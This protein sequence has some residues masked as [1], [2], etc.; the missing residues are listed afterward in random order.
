MEDIGIT[1]TRQE[2]IREVVY[3]RIRDLILEGT[4]DA[5][6]RLVEARIASRIGASRTPVREALHML[7]REGL[8]ESIPRVGYRVREVSWEEVEEICEIRAVN[9]ILA[10]RWAMSRITQEEIH[11]LEENIQ[12]AYKKAQAGDVRSFVEYDA[13]FHEGIVRASGS[14][15]LMELCEQLRRHMLRYRIKSIFLPETV[16]GALKGHREIL[17]SIKERDPRGIESAIKAH[18]EYVKKSIKRHV[19]DAHG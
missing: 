19:F 2:S 7:E 17:K 6:E 9:E 5:G 12:R 10:A 1:L 15:R 14:D 4:I 11:A 16:F 8:I 18:L 13:E 3:R